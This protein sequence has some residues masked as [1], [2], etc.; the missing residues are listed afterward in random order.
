MILARLGIG[1]DRGV[2]NRGAPRRRGQRTTIKPIQLVAGALVLAL[3]IVAVVVGGWLGAVLLGLL[4]AGAG[5]LLAL[6]WASLD[7]KV[8]VVRLVAVLATAAVAVSLAI[9]G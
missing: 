3:F 2:S 8:R 7:S 6:R 9:R 1:D 5:V 4:A